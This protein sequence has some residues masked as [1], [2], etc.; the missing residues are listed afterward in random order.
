[1]IK[2][3]ETSCMAVCD[4]CGSVWDRDFRKLYI[5]GGAR[6]IVITAVLCGSCIRD[7]KEML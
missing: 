5:A 6:Y 1:M 4:S 3:E 7:L 2:V